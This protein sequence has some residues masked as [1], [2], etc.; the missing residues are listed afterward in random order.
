M[1]ER[2]RNIREWILPKSPTRL[3]VLTAILIAV[4]IGEL[5]Y[6]HWRPSVE[7]ATEHYVIYSTAA[8]E[9]TRRVGAVM[10]QLHAAYRKV[11]ASFPQVGREHSKLKLK[12][13][14]NRD[15]FRR[16]NRGVGWAEGFYLNPYCHGYYG[17]KE[18]N[19]VHW[20]VHEAVHQLNEEVAG[21][22]LAKW[23]EEGV[24]TFFSTSIFDKDGCRLGD[25]DRNTYPLWWVEDMTLS[26]DIQKDIADK[27]IIPLR[28]IISN[29]GGPS[30]DEQFNLYYIHWWSLTHY[31][32]HYDGA[33]YRSRCLE[34]IREGADLESFEKHIGLTERVQGEWYSHLQGLQRLLNQR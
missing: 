34:L 32:F 30:L 14:K 19:P 23:A 7:I 29:R 3:R 6:R 15:E 24:A 28:A 16:C 4:L 21:F 25:L 26:G 9:Q 2:R 8:P 12:L 5:C 33:K 11:F 18:S 10:E 1:T 27:K 17:T 31:L 13:F 22:K 20:M